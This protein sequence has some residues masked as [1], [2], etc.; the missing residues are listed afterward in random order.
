MSLKSGR[1]L[2]G[3]AL[4]TA[5]GVMVSCG[6][7]GNPTDPATG[8]GNRELNS[9]DFGPGGRFEHRFTNAGAFH[10]HCIHHSPMTGSVTVSET[11][12]D[13]LANVSITRDDVPFPGA[14][15]KPGG[16]VVWTNN[17]NMVHTVTSN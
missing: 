7:G 15:V 1:W 13:T 6:G 2:M 14:T 3:I 8:G 11:A 12:T 4:V 16:R 9:G 5:L 17:S 10:Y